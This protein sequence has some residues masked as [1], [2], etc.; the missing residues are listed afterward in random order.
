L[1][2]SEREPIGLAALLHVELPTGDSNQFRGEPGFAIW[3]VIAADWVPLPAFRVGLNVGYRWNSG[4]G[5]ELPYTASFSP[6]SNPDNA[7][8]SLRTTSLCRLVGGSSS[9]TNAVCP[10]QQRGGSA[11]RYDDLLTFG[12]AASLRFAKAAELV[13]EIYG[14]QLVKSFGDKGALGAEAIGGLK[15]YVESKSYLLLAGGAGIQRS[16]NSADIRA[17]LGFIFEPSIG[18]RDGDGYKDDVDQCPDDP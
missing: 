9:I 10:G 18:D 14:A 15:I 6:V 4:A 11:V 16:M 17:V 5:A 2:R 7:S 8:T 3:P 1:L 12:V 13:G